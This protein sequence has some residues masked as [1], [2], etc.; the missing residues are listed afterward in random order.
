MRG[1]PERL[2]GYRR[3]NLEGVLILKMPLKGI[4]MIAVKIIYFFPTAWHYCLKKCLL[5]DSAVHSAERDQKL[6]G[7][8]I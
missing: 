6:I 5:K 3:N 2:H 4:N 7:K 1:V 8:S